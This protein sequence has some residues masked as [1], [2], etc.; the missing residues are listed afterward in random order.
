MRL[1]SHMHLGEHR[2]RQFEGFL[3][4][5]STDLFRLQG[6]VFARGEMGPEIEELEDHADLGALRSEF[7][8]A[9]PAPAPGVTSRSPITLPFSSIRPLVGGSR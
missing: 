8:V 9:H 7:G 4:R 5:Q 1:V 3:S 6:N 2:I